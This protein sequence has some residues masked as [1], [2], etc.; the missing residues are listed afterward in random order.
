M[1]T[2]EAFR[3]VNLLSQNYIF[4]ISSGFSFPELRYLTKNHEW[5]N[6]KNK[7][8]HCTSPKTTNLQSIIPDY[9]FGPEYFLSSDVFPET[10]IIFLSILS[11]G[12]SQKK[13]LFSITIFVPKR[14]C[15]LYFFLLSFLSFLKMPYLLR[16]R[17]K[18][19]LEPKILCSC[20]PIFLCL[21]RRSKK[22]AIL[23]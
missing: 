13:I 5:K 9:S 10:K 6:M 18:L 14:F 21:F 19:S 2:V 23:S 1:K 12:T 16:S 7:I 11:R 3:A 4:K 8:K 17:R 20:S 22:R 15:I